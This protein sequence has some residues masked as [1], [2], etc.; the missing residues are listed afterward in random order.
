[1]LVEFFLAV[2]LGTYRELRKSLFLQLLF[3]QCRQL[4]IIL[5]PLQHILDPSVHNLLSY[6]TA[7]PIVN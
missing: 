7:D 4:K 3:L 6:G 1:M 2:L 5:T